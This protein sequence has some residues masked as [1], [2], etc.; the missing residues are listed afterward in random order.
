MDDEQIE[1][2]GQVLIDMSAFTTFLNVRL[3]E[4][5]DA[6][7][8][9]EA[10]EA[11]EAYGD[12]KLYLKPLYY[13]D[14]IG[15]ALRTNPINRHAALKS[16]GSRYLKFLKMYENDVFKEFLFDDADVE[17]EAFLRLQ[18]TLRRLRDSW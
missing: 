2:I 3:N 5:S 13:I 8:L 18:N 6:N 16:V 10:F 15:R 1:L 9:D 7:L 12:A 14:D 11:D 4:M 17:Y